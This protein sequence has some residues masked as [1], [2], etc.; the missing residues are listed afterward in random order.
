MGSKTTKFLCTLEN[1]CLDGCVVS[2]WFYFLACDLSS[3]LAQEGE[4]LLNVHA[5]EPVLH[6]VNEQESSEVSHDT[7]RSCDAHRTRRGPQTTRSKHPSG[8]NVSFSHDTE[9]GEESSAQVLLHLLLIP[10]STALWSSEAYLLCVAMTVTWFWSHKFLC[11][12][13]V[14]TVESKS[15][16]WVRQFCQVIIFYISITSLFT[17][18]RS[19]CLLFYTESSIT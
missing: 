18:M 11:Q 10:L 9:G 4:A 13:W 1:N 2:N 14:S 12:L 5:I 3:L 19:E 15:H 17:N 7:I 6:L 8:S 16:E